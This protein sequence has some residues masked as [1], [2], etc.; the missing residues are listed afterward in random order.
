MSAKRARQWMT[1]AMTLAFAIGPLVAWTVDARALEER[2]A[3][4]LQIPPTPP[5]VP[6]PTPAPSPLPPPKPTPQPSPNPTPAPTP[7]PTP[8]PAPIQP[9]PASMLNAGV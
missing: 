3:D 8:P 5:P 2:T 4:E 9:T 6:S 1:G 7:T